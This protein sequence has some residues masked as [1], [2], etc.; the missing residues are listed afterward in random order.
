MIFLSSKRIEDR[1]SS[2]QPSLRR[3]KPPQG[4]KRFLGSRV[5]EFDLE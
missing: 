2:R 5:E 4:K 3:K 1:Y